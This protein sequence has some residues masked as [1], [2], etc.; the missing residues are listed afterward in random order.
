M[1]VRLRNRKPVARICSRCG[2]RIPDGK[3]YT[4]PTAGNYLC[5]ECYDRTIG[6]SESQMLG[7]LVRKNGEEWEQRRL[8]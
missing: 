3:N 8:I 4:M 1:A 6:K 7:R 2:Y 5:L